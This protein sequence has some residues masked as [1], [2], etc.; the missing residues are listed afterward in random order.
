MSAGLEA[1]TRVPG[2]QFHRT[3]L[4]RAPK[5]YRE[6]KCGCR[7]VLRRTLEIHASEQ[8][9]APRD[10]PAAAYDRVPILTAVGPYGPNAPFEG[11]WEIGLSVL[12]LTGLV[13]AMTLSIF[14]GAQSN[15]TIGALKHAEQTKLLATDLLLDLRRAESSQRGY[16]LTGNTLY[17]RGYKAGLTDLPL[18]MISL[19]AVVVGEP[20]QRARVARIRSHFD[21]KREIMAT[22]L[23][24]MDAG[25][26]AEALAVVN[27]D[28]G[29]IHMN[30]IGDEIDELIKFENNV[31]PH[32]ND[33]YTLVYAINIAVL[34]MLIVLGF[35]TFYRIFGF[36]NTNNAHARKLHDGNRK[37]SSLVNSRTAEIARVND[38]IQRYAY[39]V[40]HDLRG[41][42]VNITGFT[43]ELE[44]AEVVLVRQFEALKATYPAA[45]NP[46]CLLA[47]EEDI[48][49]A[50]RFIRTSTAKMDRLIAAVL[51]LSREGRRTVLAE[52]VGMNALIKDLVDCQAQQIEAIGAVVSI[53]A[54]PDLVSDRLALELIFGNLI[55]NAVKYLDPA[56]PGRIEI[57]GAVEGDRNIY[58]ISDNGRGISA[59]D[60]ER[61]FELFR[62]A[63]EATVPGEGL[64]LAFVRNAIYRL[65]G[66]VTLDSES[67]TGTK[68]TISLPARLETAELPEALAA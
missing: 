11:R 54:L 65:D 48:P 7:V 60:T 34:L 33:N 4:R 46:E 32:L 23:S 24:K 67:G 44:R 42:L 62:R 13:V 18:A 20:V 61:V 6:P 51:K 2:V 49:E 40:G 26:R 53:G 29:F 10:L 36:I 31:S 25:R 63:G 15:R 57:L 55:E 47:V 52:P 64:G 3:G 27:S 37:L 38:E 19:E 9:A 21:T 17:L 35:V 8:Y 30:A 45:I 68:F 56:R 43:A 12:V 41:P 39:I 28:L 1:T 50:I 16:L 66:T 58:E 14:L 22:T 5:K 59:A